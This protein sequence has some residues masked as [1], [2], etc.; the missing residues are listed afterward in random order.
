MSWDI[1]LAKFPDIQTVADIPEDF[2]PLPLGSLVGV[3]QKLTAALVGLKFDQTGWGVFEHEGGSIEVPLG[4]SDPVIGLTLF[5]RGTEAT[6]PHFERVMAALG[7][8]GIDC[9]SGEFYQRENAS[10]SFAGW[11][12]YRDQ[13]IMGD[14]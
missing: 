13:V 8:R 3:R 7:C 4:D 9:Q 12:A 14:E 6:I 5:V 2:E 11:A 1:Y 10:Q